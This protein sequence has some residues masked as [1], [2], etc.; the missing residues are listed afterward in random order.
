MT[1]RS[2]QLGHVLVANNTGLIIYQVPAGYRT[3]VKNVSVQSAAAAA[4]PLRVYVLDSGGVELFR[5]TYW[6]AAAGAS[7]DSAN[8]TVWVVM[9]AGQQLQVAFGNASG[10]SVS[11]SGSELAL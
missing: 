2:K 9:E 6:L 5:W 4:Q 11:A 7:G 1:V 8:Q 3:I 10:G